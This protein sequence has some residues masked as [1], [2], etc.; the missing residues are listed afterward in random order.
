VVDSADFP[1][2]DRLK[3]LTLQVRGIVRSSESKRNSVRYLQTLDTN[4]NNIQSA[5]DIIEFTKT[6]SAEE[7]PDRDI[8]KFLWTQGEGVD[9]DSDKYR[10][11]VKK[12]QPGLDATMRSITGGYRGGLHALHSSPRSLVAS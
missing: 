11:I 8:G 1:G 12:R 7:Y 2:A 5:E 4:P 10:G 3:K 6:F 9:V